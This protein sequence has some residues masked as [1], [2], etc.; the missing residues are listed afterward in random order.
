M[1]SLSK[2]SW[3]SGAWDGAMNWA[4]DAGKGSRTVQSIR[5]KMAHNILPQTCRGRH[6]RR[7]NSSKTT[8]RQKIQSKPKT[9]YKT[10]YTVNWPIN[11]HI[12]IIK[13]QFYDNRRNSRALIGEF[14]LSISEQT[15]EFIIYAMRQRTRADNLIV[16]Y[17]KK[18]MDVSSC[19]RRWISS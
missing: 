5:Q 7:K 19:Y 4:H 17:R 1:F 12:S 11:F 10:V 13:T 3:F 8:K 9:A 16:C 15:H 6:S 2:N 14:L 18:Q